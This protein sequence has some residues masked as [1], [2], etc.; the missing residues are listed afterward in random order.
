MGGEKES[1][2]K[3][4]GLREVERERERYIYIYKHIFIYKHIYINLIRYGVDRNLG[5]FLERL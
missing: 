1:G 3:C 5:L 4:L 2:M